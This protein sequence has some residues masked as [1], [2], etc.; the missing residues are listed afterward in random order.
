[1]TISASEWTRRAHH[2]AD[3][4][5]RRGDLHGEAWF[6]AVAETPRHLLVPSV[7]K[8]DDIGAWRKIDTTT[9]AGLDLVYSPETLVTAVERRGGHDIAVSS[10]TKPDL[11][12]RM[13]EILDVHK[14]H[15]V[16][17]IGTGTGYNAALLAHRLGDDAVFSVDVDQPL[18]DVAR[19][20]LATFGRHPT[21]VAVDGIH[22]LPEHA[23][24]DRIIA[25]CS[26]PAVPL[27]WAEQLADNGRVLV[28]L[29]LGTGAGNLVDLRRYPHRLEGRFIDRWAAF[30][31]MRHENAPA[32]RHDARASDAI[33]R[34][35][36]AP[37]QPWWDQLVVWFLAQFRLP[38][39]VTFGMRVDTETRKQITA[40]LSCPDGSWAEIG[41]DEHD[42]VRQ[43][44]E[45]GPTRLWEPIEH[46]HA[47]WVALGEPDWPRFGLTVTP[48][49]QWVWLDESN[50]DHAWQLTA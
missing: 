43:V 19:E 32:A 1:M 35:T 34:T 2:L 22:G 12:V 28:D 46:A 16:L 42:G 17:E 29:K 31:A 37:P 23:P 25:T 10:S 4:L 40:T 38:R 8:Q 36:S 7:H 13:L 14:G 24:Y 50:G 49:Q 18:V 9:P 47:Q 6:A 20:R 3:T 33:E 26:V 5:A 11:M 39:G 48:S 27:A 45:A 41:L 15:R 30:M 21:L 44:V